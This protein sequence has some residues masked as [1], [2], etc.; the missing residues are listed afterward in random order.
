MDDGIDSGGF[1]ASSTS[2]RDGGDS[3]DISEDNVEISISAEDI[4]IPTTDEVESNI[5]NPETAISVTEH[6][7]VSISVSDATEYVEWDVESVIGAKGLDSMIDNLHGV[8]NG[9]KE[10]GEGTEVEKSEAIRANVNETLRNI[11]LSGMSPEEKVAAMKTVYNSLPEGAKENIYIPEDAR[12][13]D[14]KEPFNSF[15]EARFQ[16][17]GNSG[18]DGPPEQC[19]LR[20][21]QVVDRYGSESGLYVC[22]V[23]NGVP[24]DYDSRALPYEENPEMY[25]QYEVVKDFTDFKSRIEHLSV[26]EIEQMEI[27]RDLAKPENERRSPE[28]IKEDAEDRHFIIM[29]DVAKA[30]GWQSPYKEDDLLTPDGKFRDGGLDSMVETIHK[31]DLSPLKGKIAE[32]FSYV[33]ENGIEHKKGGGEQIYLPASVDT[34]MYLGYVKEK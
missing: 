18:F 11:G 10:H 17:R 14:P 4:E 23:K 29:W 7:P 6:S 32:C 30:N 9:I 1:D 27:Q 15:G 21:G 34:L 25:H 31:G 12:F 2:G 20:P 8:I 26:E 13:L 33:D 3:I 19:T 16:W 5:G 22:E 28:Q 24:I